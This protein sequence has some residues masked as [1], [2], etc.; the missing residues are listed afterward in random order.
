MNQYQAATVF[1]NAWNATCNI[2]YPW[3]YSSYDDCLDTAQNYYIYSTN[4]YGNTLACRLHQL[5]KTDQKTE[6]K[7]IKERE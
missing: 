2:W 3:G 1:C 5:S 7:Q 4:I 6:V